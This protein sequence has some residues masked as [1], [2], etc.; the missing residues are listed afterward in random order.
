LGVK[1]SVF[2]VDYKHVNLSDKMH[3]KKEKLKFEE[4]KIFIR[5]QFFGITFFGAFCH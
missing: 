2:C 4:L 5:K 3:I 1:K